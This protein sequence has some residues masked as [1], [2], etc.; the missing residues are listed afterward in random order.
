MTLRASSYPACS[1]SRNAPCQ[2][3]TSPTGMYRSRF[4][5][6]N[7]SSGACSWSR[8][9]SGKKRQPCST[10]MP[11]PALRSAMARKTTG[12]SGP[13]DPSP[14][15]TS[16]TAPPPG[17]RTHFVS[18]K[19]TLSV[20]SSRREVV[21]TGRSWTRN[22]SR[23]ILAIRFDDLT[24][25]NVATA[26]T[27]V[28]SAVARLA[29]VLHA[30]ALIGTCLRADRASVGPGGDPVVAPEPAGQVGLV[31]E[32]GL[33]RG[34]GRR[35]AAG[36]QP[37]R[38]ADPQLPLVVAGREPV[39]LVEGPVGRVPATS[40]GRGQV[41][42]GQ[43]RGGA[44]VVDERA[45]PRGQARIGPVV[46]RARRRDAPGGVPDQQAGRRAEPLVPLQVAGGPGERSVQ[47]A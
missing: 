27:S 25:E 7:S 28:P 46:R 37:A 31:G 1:V 2:N 45:D 5:R 36:Q 41:T 19:L 38:G 15:P 22:C 40:G 8:C 6:S 4:C 44:R 14:G 16:P 26:R 35:H 39:G 34:H 18:P 21:S 17:M 30:L 10:A 20:G 24:A 33:G 9:Q 13:I 11:L 23:A 47:S 29:I 32:P 3:P 43:V 12:V 42:C